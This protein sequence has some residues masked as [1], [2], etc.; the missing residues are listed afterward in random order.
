MKPEK[1]INRKVRIK[2][3]LKET[4]MGGCGL[5]LYDSGYAP[6]SDCCEHNNE[7]SGFTKC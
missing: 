7:P 6:V 5:N 4:E 2:I 3:G 1:E